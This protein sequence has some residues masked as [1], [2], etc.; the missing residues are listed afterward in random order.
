MPR[1]RRKPEDRRRAQRLFG[2]SKRAEDIYVRSLRALVR[3]YAEATVALLARRLGGARSDGARMDA[4]RGWEPEMQR[5]E[6]DVR[7]T[8][9]TRVGEFFDTMADAVRQKG[10]K[11]AKEALGVRYSEVGVSAQIAAARDRNIRLVE[12][13]HRSYAADVRRVFEDPASYGAPWE[14]LRDALLARGA[15]SESRAELIARDQTLKLNGEIAQTRMRNA[16]VERYTWSTSLDERVRED[17]AALE[18]ETFSWNDPPVVDAATGRREHP[19]Q[20][21]QCRCVAVPVIEG[22][23]DI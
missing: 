2:A 3:A 18:G 17:H 23:E 16:G 22:L 20:D 8:I 12:D 9:T 11:A 1:R 4:I 21:F 14:D 7:A 15:V 6:A 10:L 5:L 19:G 13:A